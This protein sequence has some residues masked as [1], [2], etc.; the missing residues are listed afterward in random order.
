MVSAMP[1]Q[2]HSLNSFILNRLY[3]LSLFSH[4][5]IYQIILFASNIELNPL[6]YQPAYDNLF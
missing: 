1:V 2:T 5:T 6:L 3:R 4:E